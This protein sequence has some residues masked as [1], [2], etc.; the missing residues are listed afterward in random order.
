[1]RVALCTDYF[2]PKIGGITT[3]VEG[4]AKELMKRGHEVAVF[5]KRAQYN[6]ENFPF[7]VYRVNSFFKTERTLDIPVLDELKSALNSYSPDV[8]HGHHAF[9]PM[10]LF[11]I[12]IGR[13]MGTRTVLT[14]HSISIL[15]DF[16]KL[17]Y[18]SSYILL[19][20]RQLIGMADKI[21]AVSGA[22]AT[23]ISHFTDKS[24]RVIPNGVNTSDFCHNGKV[25]DGRSMLFVG[26]FSYRKGIYILLE[27]M[28]EVLDK[29]DNA[30]L[31]IAG[32]GTAAPLQL[33]AKGMGIDERVRVIQNADRG[34][35]LDLYK[36]SNVFVMPSVFGESFGIV[37]IEAMAAGTPI[38]ATNQGGISEVVE[39]GKT[40]FLVEKYNSG[41]LAEAII[42]ILGDQKLFERMSNACTI[43]AK[44]YDWS[45]IGDEI[46]E[47]YSV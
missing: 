23:F 26:R 5:T 21:I 41:K 20:Y 27:A 34:D 11:S 42:A 1:M 19:P 17:W 30:M 24:I 46:E 16:D 2:Y 9:S 47:A 43:A 10:S 36:H 39:D 7:R 44:R 14:N 22:A 33:L 40:G 37:L 31:T 18:P 15:Y 25:Y 29:R 3:H 38:V 32:A 28:R 13:R 35:L 4:L 6:D 12:S 8:I 45:R